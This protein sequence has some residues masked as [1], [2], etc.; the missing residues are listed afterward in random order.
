MLRYHLR[1]NT[2]MVEFPETPDGL[3]Q[4]KQFR[5]DNT[6]FKGRHIRSVL[7][8]YPSDIEIGKVYKLTYYNTNLWV[9]NLIGIAINS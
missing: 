4:I 1:N 3:R 6:E 9:K 7:Q 2:D 8:L 5:N